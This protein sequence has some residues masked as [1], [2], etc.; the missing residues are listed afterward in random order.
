MEINEL[1]DLPAHPLLVHIPVVL[2]PAA[3]LAALVAL[4]PRVRRPAALTAAA[5]AVVGGIGVFLATGSGEELEH[6]VRE[7]DQV[8]EHT[9]QGEEAEL[10]AIAFGIVALAAAATV[11]IVRRRTDPPAGVATGNPGTPPA[12]MPSAGPG[13]T[14]TAAPPEAPARPAAASP[15]RSVTW[16]P[17]IALAVSVVL[18]A[19]ATYDVVR[20]GHSGA[21]AVWHDTP[22][23]R[24]GG[25]ADGDDD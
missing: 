6:R 24:P 11:E 15:A 7:T 5:L 12:A 3:L 20:A 21:N 8:E 2:V 13:A 17:A 1:F 16:L 18:G 14:A 22:A 25:D 23:S 9:E 4:W 10:P 19:L